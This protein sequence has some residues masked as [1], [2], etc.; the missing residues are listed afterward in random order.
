MM[1]RCFCGR[2]LR[3]VGHELATAVSGGRDEYR[4]GRCG[5]RA[6]IWHAHGVDDHPLA[7]IIWN[8]AG[9]QTELVWIDELGEWRP[10]R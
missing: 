10:K 5:A 4:C 3:H 6:S 1:V 9:E 2:W 8:Q 7:G